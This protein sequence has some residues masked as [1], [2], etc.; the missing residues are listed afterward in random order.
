MKNKML[1]PLRLTAFNYLSKQMK[2][3]RNNV[4]PTKL[5]QGIFNFNFY[6]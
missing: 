5:Y 1:L 3:N 4:D 6:L 2:D